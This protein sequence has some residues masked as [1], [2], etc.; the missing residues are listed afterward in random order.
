MEKQIGFTYLKK[1]QGGF[2]AVTTDSTVL[3]S[4]YV[5]VSAEIVVVEVP[6]I[7]DIDILTNMIAIL[8]FDNDLLSGEYDH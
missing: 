6:F 4:Y 2:G 5:V 7:L 8:S 1:R 3:D